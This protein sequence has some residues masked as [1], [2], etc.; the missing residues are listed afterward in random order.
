MHQG[1][2]LD[3]LNFIS[4][5]GLLHAGLH[6]N[7]LRLA[8]PAPRDQHRAW[9]GAWPPGGLDMCL[10]GQSP[11]SETPYYCLWA[12]LLFTEAT[13]GIKPGSKHTPGHTVGPENNTL[14][15]QKPWPLPDCWAKNNTLPRQKLWKIYPWG[16]HI[17]STQSIATAPAPRPGPLLSKNGVLQ[18]WSNKP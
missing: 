9:L 18:K 6:C 5:Q 12:S 10:S 1:N 14:P 2:S 13:R 15:R 7:K 16:W 3:T 17:P 8:G 4:I 11:N